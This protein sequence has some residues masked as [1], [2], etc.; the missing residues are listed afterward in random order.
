M[1]SCEAFDRGIL[2]W[3]ISN[4]VLRDESCVFGLLLI[5]RTT[6][7]KITTTASKTTRLSLPLWVLGGRHNTRQVVVPT[8]SYR[9]HGGRQVVLALQDN[10]ASPHLN[11]WLGFFTTNVACPIQLTYV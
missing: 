7:K 11:I 4:Y 9:R 2:G 8:I 3:D 1:I 5:S 10:D 6:T